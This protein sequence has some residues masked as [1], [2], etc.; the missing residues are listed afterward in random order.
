[1]DAQ[2][3]TNSRSLLFFEKQADCCLK[4]KGFVRSMLFVSYAQLG[5]A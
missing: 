5:F 4:T 2:A 1:M 3:R